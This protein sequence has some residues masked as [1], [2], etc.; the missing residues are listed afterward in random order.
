MT[1]LQPGLPAVPRPLPAPGTD[2]RAG[3]RFRKALAEIQQNAPPPEE[4]LRLLEEAGELGKTLTAVFNVRSAEEHRAFLEQHPELY[5]PEGLQLLERLLAVETRPQ[6]R[7]R[8]EMFLQIH[9]RCQEQGL[10]QTFAKVSQAAELPPELREAL[11]ELARRGVQLRTPEDLQRALEENPDLREKLERAAQDIQGGLEV[12]PEFR[13][14][15]QTAQELLQTYLHTGN[16]QALNRAADAWQ[17]ILGHPAF[18]AAP[19]RF[20][21]AVLNDAGGVFLRRYWRAGALQ[22]LNFA[23]HC[24]QQA[25]TLRRRICLTGHPFSHPGN[26]LISRYGRTGRLEDLEEAIRVYQQAVAATPPD[27]PTGHLVS[28]IWATGWSRPLRR[29]GRLEDLK[30]PSGFGSRRSSPRRRICRDRAISSNNLG[31]GLSTV[32]GA[33]GGWKTWKK[34]SVY[35]EQA[36]AATPP[37]LPD[38]PSRL[39]NLGNGLSS[40]LRRTGRLE[41]LE[42]KVHPGLGAGGRRHAADLP[43]RAIRLRTDLGNGLISRYGRTGRLED[44]EE[45]IRSISRRSPRCRITLIAASILNNL[46]N[47]LISRYGRTG[48]LEDLEEA[49]RVYQQAVAA[50]PPDLLT[51]R[52]SQQSGQRLSR[53][54]RPHGAAGRP[55]RSHPSGAG[56]VTPRR[57]SA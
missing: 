38:R 26:G 52:L 40:P 29:T 11:E 12:P 37:D 25:V 3:K 33:R 24:W 9:R 7:Q 22:D 48:R 55:G 43:D 53:S 20:R 21:L 10:E 35:G 16:L 57:R 39:N 49:I 32:T 47:G 2:R 34:P 1:G 45:A 54:L 41:D 42:A 28:T 46:G 23:L 13:R 31:S 6:A 36:V 5:A 51:A 17:H 15:I 19:Q 27:S 56:G 50:T 18:G 30:K 8:L 44:L 14:D 4:S